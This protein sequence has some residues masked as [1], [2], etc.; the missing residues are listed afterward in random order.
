MCSPG[1]PSTEKQNLPQHGFMPSYISSSTI[2]GAHVAR[3]MAVLV[4]SLGDRLHVLIYRFRARNGPTHLRFLSN[5]PGGLAPLRD[6]PLYFV[7]FLHLELSSQYLSS[8]FSYLRVSFASLP[9]VT[10]PFPSLSLSCVPFPVLQLLCSC[11]SLL[12]SSLFFPCPSFFLPLP[13]P[14]F[15]LS[16]CFQSYLFNLISFVCSPISHASR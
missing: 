10:F 3:P 16:W 5:P 7:I 11:R 8:P 15:S 6:F 12:R 4:R 14:G 13:L 1:A 9:S 2:F